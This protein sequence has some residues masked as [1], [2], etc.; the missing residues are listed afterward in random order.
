[1][2]CYWFVNILSLFVGLNIT[3]SLTSTELADVHEK[4]IVEKRFES[5]S[6]ESCSIWISSALVHDLVWD[7]AHRKNKADKALGWRKTKIQLRTSVS[8]YAFIT[9]TRF[10]LIFVGNHF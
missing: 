2:I 8:F 5:I 1:M 7:Q 10:E 6:S 3:T 9:C 4:A